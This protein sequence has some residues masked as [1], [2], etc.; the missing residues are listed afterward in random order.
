MA[1]WRAIRVVILY[2]IGVLVL[3]VVTASAVEMI[4]HTVRLSQM[5]ALLAGI[6][7]AET[8]DFYISSLDGHLSAD[9]GSAGECSLYAE[10][11]ARVGSRAEARIGEIASLIL[12]RHIPFPGRQP[13]SSRLKVH[14]D[15]GERHIVLVVSASIAHFGL[16]WRCR[17]WS[18]YPIDHRN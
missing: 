6:L 12:A 7:A 18:T 2:P 15:V 1:T 5:K 14:A 17:R 16:D 13:K 9:G 11:V 8:T 3:L 10:M 4:Y